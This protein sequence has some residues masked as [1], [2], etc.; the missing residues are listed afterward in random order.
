MPANRTKTGQFAKG[1]SGNPRGRPKTDERIS[2]ALKAASMDAAKA[3]IEL[4][5]SIDT[6]PNVR[7]SAANSI[8]DRAYGKPVQRVEADTDNVVRVI[9]DDAA[10]EYAK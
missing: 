3:L 10:K 6:P 9:I 7:L 1:Q 4:A 8:L 5:T 2:A